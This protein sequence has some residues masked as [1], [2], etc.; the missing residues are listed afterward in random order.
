MSY[1][2]LGKIQNI[3]NKND[4]I[5][6]TKEY[7][8]DKPIYLG[9]YLHHYFIK[10]N[11]IDAFKIKNISFPIWLENDEGLAAI[12]LSSKI[13]NESIIK[14][15][16]IGK[17]P[18][19]S[20]FEFLL[21]NELEY[22]YNLDYFGNNFL[23]FFSSNP[24]IFKYLLE[25]IKKYNDVNWHRLFMN[26]NSDNIQFYTTIFKFGNFNLIYY[27]LGEAFN[28]SK[29]S[30][31]NSENEEI[32]SVIKF[33]DNFL[34]NININEKNLIKI[35][36]LFSDDELDKFFREPSKA[37]LSIILLEKPLEIIKYLIEERNINF[38]II[39]FPHGYNLIDLSY[40]LENY[41]N[42]EQIKTEY[43]WKKYK[44][45]HDF[46]EINLNGENLA[47]S[48]LNHK[49]EFDNY[50][51]TKLE[52]DILKSNPYFNILNTN[53]NTIL[54]TLIEFDFNKY[55]K[56][57]DKKDMNSMDSIDFSLKNNDGKT[58]IEECLVK[59]KLDWHDYFTN[60]QK[61]YKKN[62]KKNQLIE[63]KPISFKNYKFSDYTSFKGR[64][65][66]LCIYLTH[67]EEKY[68]NLYIPKNFWHANMAISGVND[69]F[70]STV[71]DFLLN[72]NNFP[73]II[74]FRDKNNYFIH[75]HLNNLMKNEANN[76]KYD[77]GFVFV[78]V[79]QK[80]DDRWGY[81]HANGLI[82]NFKKMQIE[83]FEPF[84]DLNRNDLEEIIE[85]EFCW[86]TGFKLIKTGDYLGPNSFQGLSNDRNVFEEKPGDFGGFCLA[87]TLWF[88]EHRI[89]N[90]NIDIK[91]LEK[92]SISR[93][94]KTEYSLLEYIRN[95][96]HSLGIILQKV[97]RKI[98]IS[99][100]RLTAEQYK[101]GEL[102]LIFKFILSKLT[103]N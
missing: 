46:S 65:P 19:K 38:D 103:F 70:F 57:L 100:K 44:K 83:M 92:K 102:E 56:I 62:K 41:Q 49:K 71:D 87:W 17:Y 50:I 47:F 69:S 40:K 58:I 84:G 5:R 97:L 6:L 1:K 45:T 27:I 72:Y 34:T 9:N 80:V 36:E 13:I 18:S 28:S 75:P 90:K 26:K 3:K 74:F 14:N 32:L 85:E 99:K 54:S 8:I 81:L 77:F 61:T 88:L 22:I 25:L 30:S 24:K 59:E 98:G 60:I 79:D 66:H 42:S 43:L 11:K 93:I 4:V 95:Y 12:H 64:L 53:K 94:L 86:N 21:K 2:I 35:F 55:K 39:V 96:S 31:F 89:K 76:G 52:L 51:L 20:I 82:F 101:K 67:L 16:D 23:F 63:N 78:S 7:P 68:K 10:Y 15:G 29:V 33:N 48:I 73:F 37:D 91:I